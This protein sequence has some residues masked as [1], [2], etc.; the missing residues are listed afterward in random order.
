MPQ[1]LIP[2]LIS[3]P[4]AAT[5]TNIQIHSS[6]IAAH[7]LAGSCLLPTHCQRGLLLLSAIASLS[8]R[9]SR[10]EHFS[11]VH[12]IC[13]AVT[14]SSTCIAKTRVMP[15]KVLPCVCID[16][17]LVPPARYRMPGLTAL[18]SCFQNAFREVCLLQLVA[19]PPQCSAWHSVR[20]STQAVHPA[21]CRRQRHTA[22][23]FICSVHSGSSP[24]GNAGP[25]SVQHR[26]CKAAQAKVGTARQPPVSATCYAG[27]NPIQEATS[28]SALSL[29]QQQLHSW[30]G[31][32]ALLVRLAFSCAA[33]ATA[34]RAAGSVPAPRCTAVP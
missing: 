20:T 18:A 33:T 10:A 7:L 28:Q 1:L 24:S 32:A 14:R 6:R 4:K 27:A 30:G 8:W 13:C 22:G 17:D 16:R 12:R 31:C 5:S 19:S 21:G 29:Q 9:R 15:A 34:A 26:L 11:K 3:G 2:H 23:L 25:R